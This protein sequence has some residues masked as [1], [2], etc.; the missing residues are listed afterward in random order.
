MLNLHDTAIQNVPHRIVLTGGPLAGKSTIMEHLQQTYGHK[1]RFMTEVASMLLTSGYPQPGRDIDFSEA[2][3][4][5]INRVILPTQLNM[6]NG[7]LHAAQDNRMPVVFFDRGLLDP[8]AYMSGGKEVLR[9]Q[10]GMDIDAAY[11]RYSMVIHLQSLACI[12]PDLYTRLQGTNP[13]RYD[14]AESARDRDEALVAAWKDHPNWVFVS[15]EGGMEAVL[16]RVINV[17]SPILDVEIERKWRIDCQ[18]PFPDDLPSA[19]IEQFYLRSGPRG[20]LRVRQ[21]GD[22]HFIAIKS[23]S[24]GAAR[25]EWEQPI[26]EGVFL[27]LIDEATPRISKT[28]YYMPHGEHTLEIDVYDKPDGLITVECEFH[29]AEAAQK[30][31]LPEWLQPYA[32][33]V[34]DDIRYKNAVMAATDSAETQTQRELVLR[35]QGG[36][37]EIEDRDDGGMAAL[38]EIYGDEDFVSLQIRSWDEEREWPDN[39]LELRRLEGKKVMAEV[40]IVGDADPEPEEDAAKPSDDSSDES[41]RIRTVDNQEYYRQLEQQGL[42]KLTPLPLEIKEEEPE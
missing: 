29:S 17:L 40:Y 6:E 16:Q 37:T 4:D 32:T 26:P 21:L 12:D 8:A 23:N 31:E 27:S 28:R 41:P 11:D 36:I 15:A 35:F 2:W 14:S 25:S 24:V 7:H 1:A 33:D 9:D 20:E 5:Y 18:N 34:T 42:L 39:H 3:L 13:A 19:R 30:F 10:Y 22:R 38:V